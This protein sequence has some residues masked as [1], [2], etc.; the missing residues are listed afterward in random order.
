VLPDKDGDGFRLGSD[1]KRFSVI[2]TVSDSLSY[3]TTW[4]QVAELLS[5]YWAAV[6]V[7]V[8]VNGMHDD[9]FSIR[10]RENDI[11]ASMYTGEGGAGIT[12]ILD[13]RYYVPME[14]FGMFGNGWWAWRVKSTTDT[15][16][17]PPQEIK[18]L[19]LKY[20]KEVLGAPT[21]EGQ[22]AAMKEI[23]DIAADEFWCIGTT[24][25]SP[26]YYPFNTRLGNMPETW[27]DGWIEGVQKI[28]Y[29][30]QWYLMQ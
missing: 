11:E 21:Q 26:L 13:P 25:N 19:R 23:L 28:T 3:G 6:G 29:P 4:V 16:V 24:R 22:I 2:M 30:E 18:D 7:E 20:E 9:Q 8:T 15:H 27:I 1:G 17:E 14:Q 12:A 10:R 5:G